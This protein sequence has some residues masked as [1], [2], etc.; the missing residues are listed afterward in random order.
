[1]MQFKKYH[2]FENLEFNYLGIFQKLKIAHFY[3]KILS[4][5]LRLN[6]TPNT[7]GCYGL[8]TNNNHQ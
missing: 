4:I 7:L 1:M 8:T 3:G 2:T 6:F 5:S